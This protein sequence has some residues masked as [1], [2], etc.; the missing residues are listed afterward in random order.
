MWNY[1]TSRVG[2]GAYWQKKRSAMEARMD[3]ILSALESIQ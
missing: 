2:F 3:E 1:N